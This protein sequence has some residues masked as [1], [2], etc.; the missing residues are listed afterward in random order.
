MILNLDPRFNPFPNQP[1]VLHQS[2]T[3]PGGEPHI[4]LTEPKKLL[5]ENVII[6]HR[7]ASF[8]DIGLV[9][10]ATDALKRVGVANIDLFLPYFPAAR[11]DRVAVPGEPLSVKVYANLIN[12]QNY[13]SV[14]IFDPHSEV[15][16]ALLDNCVS[17]STEKLIERVIQSLPNNTLLVSPD[18]GATKKV[19]KIAQ[20]LNQFEVIECSKVRSVSTGALSD[21]KVFAKDLGGRPCL[22]VDDICD[23][24]GTFI[25]LAQKLKQ[26]NAGPLFLAVSHGIFSKGLS[27][28]SA[29]FD[30]IFTT[31]SIRS[32][33]ENNQLVRIPISNCLTSFP[34]MK[35]SKVF[36][37]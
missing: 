1:Q 18:H 15:A 16:P 24:G 22:I 7:V 37:R 29:H 17:F 3:F 12:A 30:K 36:C 27:I 23:G 32:N 13:R 10:M 25:G 28:L 9:L 34:E 20:F 14:F 2:F 11:Q 5:S 33:I 35:L 8:N 6:T 26:K 19:Y 4:K 31:N 21:F